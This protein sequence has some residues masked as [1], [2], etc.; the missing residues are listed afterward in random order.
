MIKLR[1][2]TSFDG[3]ELLELTVIHMCLIVCLSYFPQVNFLTDRVLN[4]EPILK[5]LMKERM[6][7][8]N[9]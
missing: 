2:R 8:M 1:N 7:K 4:R 6:K 5:E 9:K 3:Y